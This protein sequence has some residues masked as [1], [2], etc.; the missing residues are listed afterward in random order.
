[1]IVLSLEN[2]C[3]DFGI[4]NVIRS[5]SFALQDGEKMGLVGQN[6]SGKSTLLRIITGELSPS[7]GS[8]H[9]SK[10]ANIGYIAQTNDIDPNATLINAMLDVFG[11]A[12]SLEQKIHDLEQAMHENSNESEAITLADKYHKTLDRYNAI[13]GYAY[14]GMIQGVLRGL[15]FDENQ[16][17]RQVSTFS[18]GEKAR[19]SL[20]KLLLKK[21]NILLL[22]E[23]SNHLDLDALAWLENYLQEYNG[24]II[25]IS[26]DRY[27][28]DNVCTSIGEL[29]SGGIIKYDG[30][31][32]QYQKK[33]AITREAEQKAY[34]LQTKYIEHEKEIIKMYRAQGASNEKKKKQAVS[35]EKRLAKL[36]ILERPDIEQQI[37]FSFKARLRSGEEVLKVHDISKS[38]NDKT[39]FKNISFDVRSGDRIALIGKN[40]I[41]KSTLFNIIMKR[42]ESDTGYT[43]FGTN[44]DPG[45]FEQEHRLLDMNKTILDNVWDS[46]PKMQQHEVRSALGMFLF[47]GDDVFKTLDMLSGGERARVMLTKLMLSQN[48]LLLLD[49]PTNHLDADSREVLESAL[50]DYNGTI[51]AISHDRYFI[52]K[53]ANKILVL[54]EENI[55]SYLGNYDDYVQKKLW[56]EQ[57]SQE[58]I[59]I[60]KTAQNKQ[61]K[62]DRL[63]KIKL[64]NLETKI[65]EIEQ[66]MLDSEQRSHELELL[67][68]N[69]DT[70]KDLQMAENFRLE[71]QAEESKREELFEIMA[72]LDEELSK[73]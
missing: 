61:K 59:V 20:A 7:S 19:L 54:E 51:F 67:L 68:A 28:L 6:G 17:N 16:Y 52:N 71:Y 27:F 18:G 60:N 26:H 65:K 23:P 1:M 8:V 10:D 38:F 40:G 33:R 57:V 32:T 30:N 15:G 58:S 11:E 45:Y 41:G 50:Q 63:E 25:V 2:I 21:P 53:F 43:A 35:R 9:I 22:D 62:R 44:V 24:A 47:T 14:M 55:T 3:M 5:A 13:E 46:F 31:Y 70:Y 37:R 12:I 34:E 29:V 64:R 69:P 36:D 4:E 42:V 66:K 39:L 72:E 73:L 48:N 56:Q 49:E